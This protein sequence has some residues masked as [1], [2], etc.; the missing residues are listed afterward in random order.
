MVIY[1]DDVNLMGDNINTMKKNTEA[2]TDPTKKVGREINTQKTKYYVLMSRHR[3]AWQT[4]NIKLANRSF[5]NV[6]K[7]KYF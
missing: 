3:N 4:R 7:F 2:L 5:E 1:V 6:A